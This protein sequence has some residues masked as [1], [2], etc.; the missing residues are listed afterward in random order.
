[1]MLIRPYP[2]EQETLQS[3]VIRLAKFN[4]YQFEHWSQH[5]SQQSI[6][7]RQRDAKSRELLTSYLHSVTG[8]DNVFNLFDQ[9]Q[10]YNKDKRHFDYKSIKVCPL[11]FAE[12]KG[13]ILSL[14][15]LRYYLVCTKHDT[16]L[17]DKCSKCNSAI[18]ENTILQG[19]CGSCV[20]EVT[21][22]ETEVVAPDSFSLELAR[23]AQNQIFDTT[24]D[25]IN[26]L[27]II[28]TKLEACSS[29][30]Y[31]DGQALWKK[32]QAYSIEE[33]YH[34]QM[35]VAELVENENKLVSAIGRYVN[36]ALEEKLYDL[37]K[38]LVKFKSYI[39]NEKF[40][41]MT[42]AIRTFVLTSEF[43]EDQRVGVTWLNNLFGFESKMFKNFI[44]DKYPSLVFKQSVPLNM[45]KTIV[46]DFKGNLS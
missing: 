32:K 23:A 25:L 9:W 2:D 21:T 36:L 17:V 11:C 19:K 27:L 8:M 46:I 7:L 31:Q 24:V 43:T 40:P 26:K 20:K 4:H 41:M 12:N 30:I 29:F 18:T 44:I 5:L 6:S 35:Q 3:Y 42:S 33:K 37:G 1:M 45:A 14:W 39:G 34:H 28:Y 15:A 38:V 10:F 16:L 22:F 13:K